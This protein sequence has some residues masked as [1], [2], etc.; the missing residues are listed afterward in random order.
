[1]RKILLALLLTATSVVPVQAT[2]QPLTVM[3]R[4]LYLGADVGVAME[5]IPDFSAAAQFMWSQVSAT[6]FSKRAPLLAQ[7]VISQNADVVGLQEATHWYCKKNLLSKKVIVFDFTEQFLEATRKLGH[8]YVLASKDGV[9]AFNIGYSIPA[10]PYLTMVTD[11]ETFQPMFGSDRAACGFE[12]GDALVVKKEIASKIIQVGN[13]EYQTSYSIIPKIMTIY[14]GYTW[15]DIDYYGSKVRIVSTHLES[16]WDSNKV[17]NAVLQAKQ[18]TKDLSSTKMPIIVIG[19]FNSDPRDP[20]PNSESNPGGQPEASKA[21]RA[22]V[23]KPSLNTAIDTCN[24]YWLMRN[25]GFIDVGPDA[26]NVENFTWGMNALLTGP[27]EKRFKA[28]IK[29][30]NAYGFTD[31]LDYIFLKNGAKVVSSKIIGNTPPKSGLWPSDHASVVAQ[32][33]LPAYSEE[34]APLDS[35]KPFPISFWNWVGIAL[36]IAAGGLITWRRRRNHG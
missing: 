25:S 10:I 5:L 24:A 16:L 18:L 34:S 19:D 8:E 33:S 36:V 15:A 27:D 20:R 14:R 2:Q 1:M 17:P 22:Q 31:R 3:S 30:G 23:E 9:D 4:N 7:E 28:A 35:H 32:V 11:P 21:C 12:I 26:Q 6:D 13:S 29:M